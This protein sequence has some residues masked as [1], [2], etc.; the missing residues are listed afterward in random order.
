MVSDKVSVETLSMN[1]GSTPTVWTS[2]GSTEYTFS[3]SQ[4]SEVGTTITLHVNEESAEFLDAWKMSETLRKFCD[5]LPYEIA[6]LDEEKVTYP[7]KED[8][9]E[10]KSQAP[11]PNE[12]TVINETTPIWKREYYLG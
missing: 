6:V 2:E 1:D 4:K 3:D 9:S 12:P 10:D 5:F 11:L 7:A 8:G